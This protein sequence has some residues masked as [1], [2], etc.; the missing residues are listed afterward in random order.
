VTLLLGRYRLSIALLLIADRFSQKS[1]APAFSATL[2]TDTWLFMSVT[3][4][5]IVILGALTFFPLL[6]LG[7]IA[8]GFQFNA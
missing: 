6:V 1:A 7:S 4:A 8:E 3:A 5:T 2:S